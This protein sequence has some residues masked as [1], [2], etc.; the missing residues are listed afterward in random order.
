MVCTCIAGPPGRTLKRRAEEWQNLLDL[1]GTEFEDALPLFVSEGTSGQKLASIH[2]SD[3]L[4]FLF[5]EF[6]KDNG[7]IVIFGHALGESDQ[8][9][10]DVLNSETKRPIAISILKR[11]DVRQKK[12][13]II[14]SLPK[15]DLC[16]FDASTHPLGSPK[17]VVCPE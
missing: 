4:S 5:G 12:A 3:Y 17:L 11:G 7:P 1:F 16:F 6:S 10:A 9:I 14:D 13:S 8:H 2:R 15:A